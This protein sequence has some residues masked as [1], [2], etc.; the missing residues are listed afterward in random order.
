MQHKRVQNLFPIHVGAII[1]L[2]VFDDI[3]NVAAP[4]DGMA[5]RDA[6]I[7]WQGYIVRCQ[8]ANSD[9]VF[10]QPI[11]FELPIG[12]S[13]DE[14]GSNLLSARSNQGRVVCAWRLVVL[15]LHTL[16]LRSPRCS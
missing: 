3:A 15:R 2:L 10:V 14:S 1:A 13:Q 11:L 4:N 6:A 16:F 9:L 5:A 8:A 7:I 12:P